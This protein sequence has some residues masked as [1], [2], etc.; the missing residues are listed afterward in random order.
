VG[1]S[2]GILGSSS[3]SPPEG[4]SVATESP[5]ASSISCPK[6]S[7]RRAS[8]VVWLTRTYL[9][10]MPVAVLTSSHQCRIAVSLYC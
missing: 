4:S 1:G 7:G 9:Q 2:C 8:K 6:V 5:T 3:S 10:G